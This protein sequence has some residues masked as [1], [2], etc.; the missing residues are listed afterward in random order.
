MEEG[1]LKEADQKEVQ[2]ETSG[3]APSWLLEVLERRSNFV[4]HPIIY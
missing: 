4:T 2:D 1:E 3:N